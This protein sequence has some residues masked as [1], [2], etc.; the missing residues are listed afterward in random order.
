MTM[1]GA[2]VA[3]SVRRQD[4][5]VFVSVA[6]ELDA[7]NALAFAGNVLTYCAQAPCQVII[8]A[9]KLDFIDSAGIQG[10]MR[11]LHEVHAGGGEVFVQAASESVHRILEITGFARMPA[12]HVQARP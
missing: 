5:D 9:A 8:D 10:L 3:V 6:G 7:Y 1:L 12:V 11:I 2:G 4:G